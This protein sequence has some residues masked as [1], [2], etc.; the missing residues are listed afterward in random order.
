MIVLITC[1]SRASVD[2]P[3]G[4]N[5]LTARKTAQQNAARMRN[6]FDVVT[7][8][9]KGYPSDDEVTPIST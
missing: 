9:L 1:A 6:S 4:D 7:V 2:D 3:N 5:A 8:R